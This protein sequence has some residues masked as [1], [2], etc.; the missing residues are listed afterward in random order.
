MCRVMD[1]MILREG[2]RFLY[3]TFYKPVENCTQIAV[4]V[5][6]YDENYEITTEPYIYSNYS[7]LQTSPGVN[8]KGICFPLWRECR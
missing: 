4:T 5:D 6:G 8:R 7:I 1:I 3:K 2:F